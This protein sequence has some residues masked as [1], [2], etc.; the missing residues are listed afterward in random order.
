M[1]AGFINSGQSRGSAV[2]DTTDAIPHLIA[3]PDGFNLKGSPMIRAKAGLLVF[4][5]ALLGVAALLIIVSQS[6]FAFGDEG[7]HLLASQ[8]ISR[9]KAPYRDFLSQHPP[10]YIYANALWMR[11]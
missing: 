4:V 8:L 9:G 6:I 2:V 1:S 11:C 3:S 5:A 7:F 10:L